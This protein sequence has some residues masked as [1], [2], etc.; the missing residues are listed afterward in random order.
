[1]AAGEDLVAAGEDLVAA[2]AAAELARE[3]DQE[4][5]EAWRA[6]C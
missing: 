4:L 5:V 6:D 1:V 2:G 3:L